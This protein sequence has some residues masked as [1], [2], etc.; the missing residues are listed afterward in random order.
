MEKKGAVDLCFQQAAECLPVRLRRLVNELPEEMK[1]TAEEFRLRVGRPMSIVLP[2]GEQSPWKERVDGEDLET[3]V[4]MATDFSRYCAAETIRNGYLPARGGCR[5]GLCG[6]AV[7]RDGVNT[8]LRD[9]TSVAIR[10][11]REKI[12]IA[13][14]IVPQLLD[15]AEVQSTLI[16]APPGGGKTTLLRDLI[17]CF[18]DG[19]EAWRPYRVSVVDERGE[20]GVCCQGEPQM[21]LGSRTDI[22]DGCPKALGIPMVMRAMNPQIIAVDEI[23]LKED[24][25]CLSAAANCGVR[26]LAT[27]HAS[28]VEELGKKPL[29]SHLMETHAFRKAILI[30]CKDGERTYQVEDLPC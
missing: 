18:S 28:D 10:I 16:L 5:I 17:R 15:D 24:I 2:D 12:G 4:N 6:T 7:I 29:Y 25:L 19:G 14:E 22:L 26:L 9:L 23:T 13:R 11:A 1:E 30:R 20:I 21:D 3:V 27:I 8:N